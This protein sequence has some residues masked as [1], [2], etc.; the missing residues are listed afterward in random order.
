MEIERKQH[1]HRNNH[2]KGDTMR[3]SNRQYDILKDAVVWVS[4]FGTL[5]FALSGIWG[6]PYGEQV[7]G[8]CTAIVAFMSAIM[9]GSTNTYRA[10][11]EQDNFNTEGIEEMVEVEEYE[12]TD[13]STEE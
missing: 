2:Q 7:V 8:T 9:K 11:K 3:L 1:E 6:L 13:Y 4:A 10:E 5:Y 12:D